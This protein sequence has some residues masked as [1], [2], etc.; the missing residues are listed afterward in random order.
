MQVRRLE[1]PTTA[2]AVFFVVPIVSRERRL[3]DITKNSCDGVLLRQRQ[4]AGAVQK[5]LHL[6]GPAQKALD[7]G[8]ELLPERPGL[9]SEGEE[10]DCTLGGTY[11]SAVSAPK[12]TAVRSPARLNRRFGRQRREAMR[13][14]RWVYGSTIPTST[15]PSKCGN[16]N[17]P[18][19]MR[20]KVF[21]GGG[22]SGL[23]SSQMREMSPPL[24]ATNF[25][26]PGNE[27]RTRRRPTLRTI[28]VAGGSR[29]GNFGQHERRRL[30]PVPQGQH[31]FLD[32]GYQG[33]NRTAFSSVSTTEIAH[34][35]QHRS[36]D[37]VPHNTGPR[38]DNPVLLSDSR[39]R[40]KATKNT[41]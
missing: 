27:P 21:R 30:E 19:I 34:R 38:T 10:R 14:R 36:S 3:R 25:F 7:L 9:V 6:L 35:K 26:S 12:R 20:K 16:R 39:V 18:I 5:M 33:R 23:I 17:R 24:R 1:I 28:A 22:G 37:A 31:I 41:N 4:G 32:D 15:S 2:V 40:E 13:G 8:V 29:H 11:R